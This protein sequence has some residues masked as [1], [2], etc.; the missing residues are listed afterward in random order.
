MS[1]AVLLR[2]A[3]LAASLVASVHAAGCVTFDQNWNLYAL[4][5]DGSDY[6]LG[7]QDSWASE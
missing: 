3:I 7:M 1:R 4:G 2:F 5:L 6:F